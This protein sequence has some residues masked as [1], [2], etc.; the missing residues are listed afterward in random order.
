MAEKFYDHFFEKVDELPE[1]KSKIII[2]GRTAHEDASRFRMLELLRLSDSQALELMKLKYDFEYRQYYSGNASGNRIQIFD[3]FKKAIND[4]LIPDIKNAIEAIDPH[5]ASNFMDGVLHPGVLFYF[6]SM[7][8]DGDL[9]DD[10]VKEK[11]ISPSFAALFEYAVCHQDYGI[12]TYLTRWDDWIK[13]KTTKYVQNDKTCMAILS[14]M[15]NYPTEFF[16]VISL[17]DALPDL[18]KPTL[19]TAFTKL[20][21]MTEFSKST[22]RMASKDFLVHDFT[23]STQRCSIDI[24]GTSRQTASNL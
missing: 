11:E 21:A 7:L 24:R 5:V 3:D 12:P 9:Y 15:A 13:D 14:H 4:K 23:V 19:T 18:D 8:M 20:Q 1:C 17:L 2:T 10:Y 6:I 16:D 22:L